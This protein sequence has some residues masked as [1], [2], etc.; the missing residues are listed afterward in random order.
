MLDDLFLRISFGKNQLEI[1]KKIANKNDD[2]NSL[3]LG[4][5]VYEK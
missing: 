2:M 1:L 4:K 5:S 3:L